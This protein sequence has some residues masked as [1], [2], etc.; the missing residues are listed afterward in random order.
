MNRH[1]IP[2]QKNQ[3]HHIRYQ[4]R[5]LLV[6]YIHKRLVRKFI[7]TRMSKQQEKHFSW[8]MV[9]TLCYFHKSSLPSFY[10]FLSFQNSQILILEPPES[11]RPHLCLLEKNPLRVFIHVRPFSR[12]HLPIWR[13]V[14]LPERESGRWFQTFERLDRSFITFLPFIFISK[15]RFRVKQM[16]CGSKWEWVVHILA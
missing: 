7:L 11:W 15:Y 4:M 16:K 6:V 12:S 9:V 13:R 1:L 10:F 14:V 5:H 3:R 8:V 2:S